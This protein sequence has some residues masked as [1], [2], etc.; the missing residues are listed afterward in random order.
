MGGL[1]SWCL[2]VFCPIDLQGIQHLVLQ[3]QVLYIWNNKECGAVLRKW[4]NSRT[5]AAPMSKAGMFFFLAK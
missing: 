1:F 3:T 5:Q 2:V 4:D